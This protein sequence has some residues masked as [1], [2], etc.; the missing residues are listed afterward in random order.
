MRPL[1]RQIEEARRRTFYD[2]EQIAESGRLRSFFCF[3]GVYA[4]GCEFVCMHKD[5]SAEECENAR[6]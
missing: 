3:L 6:V 4:M 2:F 5:E 1:K